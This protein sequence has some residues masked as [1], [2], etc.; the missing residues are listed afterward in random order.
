M[1]SGFRYITDWDL[2]R[3]FGRF[4]KVENVSIAKDA[5][6]GEGCHGHITM[7]DQAGAQAAI[8]WLNRTEFEGQSMSITLAN[9]QGDKVA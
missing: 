5:V 1:D 4:G 7:R 9:N 2:K 3:K 8:R 6:R